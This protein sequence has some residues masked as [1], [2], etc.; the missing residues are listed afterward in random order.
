MANGT[1]DGTRADEAT[2]RAIAA[3][4]AVG[5]PA[6][7]IAMLYGR[8]AGNVRNMLST[9]DMQNLVAA[10]KNRLNMRRQIARLKA[11]AVSPEVMD[12]MIAKSLDDEHK[13]SMAA[14][15]IVLETAEVIGPASHAPGQTANFNL[16]VGTDAL[17]EVALALL[18]T[19][20]LEVDQGEPVLIT[21]A[22]V[23][24]TPEHIAQMDADLKDLADDD[25]EPE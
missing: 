7:H 5:T 25:G 18:S 13:D 9:E 14:G 24:P 16:H 11:Q 6:A 2:R 10:E 8:S 12:K 19:R 3:D 23:V 22:D 21:G 4:A 20:D 1:S 15:K 17:K